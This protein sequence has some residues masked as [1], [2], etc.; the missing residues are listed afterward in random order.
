MG[1]FPVFGMVITVYVI[2]AA[3]TITLTSERPAKAAHPPIGTSTIST[4]SIMNTMS[5]VYR[6]ER[7]F[8]WLLGAA[9]GTRLPL[10]LYHKVLHAARHFDHHRVCNHHHSNPPGVYLFLVFRFLEYW[11]SDMIPLPF[12]W[13]PMRAVAITLVPM[14]IMAAIS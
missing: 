12:C 4:P 8:L 2:C 7:R 6:L 13:T 1:V 14:L 11:M 5:V 9:E 3:L 10:G